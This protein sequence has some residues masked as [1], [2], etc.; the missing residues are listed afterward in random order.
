MEAPFLAIFLK[1]NIPI[2]PKLRPFSQLTT[3]F[4]FSPV[5]RHQYS[6]TTDY[7]IVTMSGDCGRFVFFSVDC[8]LHPFRPNIAF[9]FFIIFIKFF[10]RLRL[11]GFNNI[12]YKLCILILTSNSYTYHIMRRRFL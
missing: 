9:I 12:F 5:F 1:L 6:S 7:F 3:I 8:L 2:F 10:K 11:I 4:K